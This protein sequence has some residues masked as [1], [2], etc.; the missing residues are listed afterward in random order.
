MYVDSVTSSSMIYVTWFGVKE[1][2]IF[3]KV[4]NQEH[5][6]GAKRFVKEFRIKSV[7]VVCD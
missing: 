5:G 3:I 1:D 6:Y 4:L 7:S 2:K